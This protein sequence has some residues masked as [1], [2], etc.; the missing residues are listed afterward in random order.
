MHICVC[1]C[2]YV[3]AWRYIYLSNLTEKR[4]F[5]RQYT[6]GFCLGPKGGTVSLLKC[7]DWSGT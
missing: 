2:V 6:G 3:C 7:Y 1:I 5:G 4:K